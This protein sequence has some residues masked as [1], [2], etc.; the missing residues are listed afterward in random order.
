MVY[1]PPPLFTNS[2]LCS[3]I[4]YCVCTVCSPPFTFI[5]KKKCLILY[6]LLCFFQWGSAVQFSAVQLSP[7]L[8]SSLIQC[9]GVECSEGQCG[10][11][12]CEALG[13]CRLQSVQCSLVCLWQWGW[14][15]VVP[16]LHYTEVWCSIVQCTV[17]P[18]LHYI[19]VYSSVLQCRLLP[20]V[21]RRPPVGEDLSLRLLAICSAAD[22]IPK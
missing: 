8:L 17:V 9:K 11:V 21:G 18:A 19:T 22:W 5:Q 1:I 10:A 4:Y 7:R 16:V 13:V 15:A 20:P 12:P 2:V 14:P 3:T 6:G